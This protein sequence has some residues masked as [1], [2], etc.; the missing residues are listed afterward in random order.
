MQAGILLVGHGSHL[1]SDSSRPVHDLARRLREAGAFQEVRV[2]FWKE[3]P[4]LPYALELMESPEVFVVPVFTSVGYFT[5]GV[6]PRELGLE[7]GESR[8]SDRRVRMCAPVGT[9]SGMARVV[10]ERARETAPLSTERAANGALVVIGH[11]T[12]LHPES[13]D[14]T[15]LVADRLASSGPYGTVIPAFLDQSPRVQEVLEG[16][17]ALDVILVPFFIAEGWH[18]KSTIPAELE[19]T[20]SRTERGGMT[21]WYT[22]P[23]GTHPTMM[24]VVLDLVAD[25]VGRTPGAD[26]GRMP[27][28]TGPG[29]V[30]P[31]AAHPEAEPL[32]I[33]QA[34][35]AFLD[36]LSEYGAQPLALL[37]VVVLPSGNGRFELRHRED[38]DADPGSLRELGSSEDVVS[39][40]LV[41]RNGEHRPLR[42]TPDLGSGWRLG[43]L[44]GDG[45]WQGLGH[46]YP[47]VLLHRHLASQGKLPVTRYSEFGAR[48]T[49]MYSGVDRLSRE[50]LSAVV[51]DCCAPSRCLRTPV[52]NPGFG[53]AAA[54]S[55]AVEAPCPVPCAILLSAVKDA[56]PESPGG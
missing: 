10:L 53:S 7:G 15:R 22:G 29:G 4:F 24:D 14:T 44:T 13:S 42:T 54:I 21:L 43:D 19:L 50:R 23:V 47:A 31:R 49:G 27:D 34:K 16:I 40:V 41:S 48:Q 28:P 55:A 33:H 17:S 52:W 51:A 36:R 38:L 37:E 9:H 8:T 5:D 46:L 32:A 39:L 26:V 18:T 1:S 25:E 30:R 35:R 3:E 12:D 6:V 20:G 11:G 56:L 45:V 2:A